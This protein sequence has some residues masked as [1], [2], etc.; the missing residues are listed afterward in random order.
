MPPWLE[1]HADLRDHPKVDL[2]MDLLAVTRRDACGL[3]HFIWWRTLTYAPSGDLSD[4]TDG[5]IARWADWDGDP[6]HLVSAL[7]TAGFMDASRTIHDWED[8]AGRWIDRR[9]ADADR[10]REARKA[11]AGRSNGSTNGSAAPDVRD[12]S[13][14]HPPRARTPARAPGPDLTGPNPTGHHRTPTTPLP[15]PPAEGELGPTTAE[16]RELWL[17]AFGQI[18]DGMLPANVEKVAALEPL[19]RGPDGGLRLRAPP[20]ADAARFQGAVRAALVNAGDA[21]GG[22]AVIVT[23]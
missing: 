5:Q 16:D 17:R 11:A 9:N 21:D 22:K 12:V 20:W 8:F 19:G 13:G 6:G 14:G 3:L 15:P 10:K 2:L 23:T 7:K 4:F 1:S 18:T